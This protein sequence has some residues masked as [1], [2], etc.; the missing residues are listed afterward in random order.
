MEWQIDRCTSAAAATQEQVYTSKTQI[1]VKKSPAVR[2]GK[3]RKSPTCMFKDSFEHVEYW[4]PSAQRSKTLYELKCTLLDLRPHINATST[5]I[6]TANSYTDSSNSH[7][8]SI[9]K[10]CVWVWVRES[11]HE[12]VGV[13][14][15][16]YL[17]VSVMHTCKYFN[18]C[19][20]HK[21][22]MIIK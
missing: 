8:L 3:Q 1:L 9:R 20:G 21:K 14:G 19:A 15:H 22:W 5:C 2:C 7:V 13:Y 4:L 12:C 11:V 17:S 6:H 10:G 18:R 16:L